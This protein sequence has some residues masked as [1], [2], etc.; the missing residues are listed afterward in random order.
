M[1]AK[2]ASTCVCVWHYWHLASRRASACGIDA[3]QALAEHPAERIDPVGSHGYS[4]PV[5][6]EQGM[7]RG[8][9]SRGALAHSRGDAAVQGPQECNVRRRQ[10]LR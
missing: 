1:K 6:A 10:V 7:H 5:A 4:D 9:G 3:R 8:I 2:R